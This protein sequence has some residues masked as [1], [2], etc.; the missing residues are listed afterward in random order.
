MRN[1]EYV[2]NTASP[3]LGGKSNFRGPAK[4][5]VAVFDGAGDRRGDKMTYDGI[6]IGGGPAGM[7]AA[8]RAAQLGN[9]VLLL[10]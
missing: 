10:K 4:G 1:G 2:R 3:H 7:L 9:Q 5:T 6:I 8:I